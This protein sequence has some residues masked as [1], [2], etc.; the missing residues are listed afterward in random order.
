MPT[1][2]SFSHPTFHT[3]LGSYTSF[4]PVHRAA[5]Y[6]FVDKGIAAHLCYLKADQ[7]TFFLF[8]PFLQQFQVSALKDRERGQ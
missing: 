1:A 6:M 2:A 5:L 3:L 7:S 4:L 8:N